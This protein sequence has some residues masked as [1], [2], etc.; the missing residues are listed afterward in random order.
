MTS[1][2][3]FSEFDTEVL[4]S[5]D[6]DICSDL[7][8]DGNSS[9]SYLTYLTGD[10]RDIQLRGVQSPAIIELYKNMKKGDHPVHMVIIR[11]LSRKIFCAQ[12][13]PVLVCLFP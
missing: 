5:F 9:S 13:G 1:W 6:D 4:N 7:E 10:V 8:L 2:V 12:Y 11:Q 3:V